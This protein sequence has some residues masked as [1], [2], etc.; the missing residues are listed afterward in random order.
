MTKE[1]YN[2]LP[3][4]SKVWFRP[5]FFVYAFPGVIR[6]QDGVRTV[7]INFF[8]HGQ[9]HFRRVDYNEK[10][11]GWIRRFEDGRNV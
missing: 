2:N 10:F 9:C 4:G 11:Y 8:G 6:E 5:D 3:L 7:Y 1:E